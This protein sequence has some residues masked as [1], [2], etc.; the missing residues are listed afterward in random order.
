MVRLLFGKRTDTVH[1]HFDFVSLDSLQATPKYNSSLKQMNDFVRRV[2]DVELDAIFRSKF[3][4]SINDLADDNPIALLSATQGDS[5]KIRMSEARF[6]FG[7]DAN[8]LKWSRDGEK[9]E[10]EIESYGKES[11]QEGLFEKGIDWNY[12]FFN[13]FV[14]KD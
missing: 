9:I 3:Y 11:I 1:F 4:L 10:V 8:S 2:H 6:V 7:D 12:N 5:S 13:A 14:A